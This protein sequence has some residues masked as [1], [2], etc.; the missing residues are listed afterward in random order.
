MSQR[1][2]RR[3]HNQRSPDLL[4]VEQAFEAVFWLVGS[5]CVLFFQAVVALVRLCCGGYNSDDT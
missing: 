1:P 5:T 4:W 3:N 2:R